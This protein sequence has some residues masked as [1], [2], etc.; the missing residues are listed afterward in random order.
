MVHGWFYTLHVSGLPADS[1]ARGLEGIIRDADSRI[2][3]GAKA[4][5]VGVLSSDNR[6]NWASNLS[7]LVSLSPQ[8]QKTLDFI[9]QSILVL[10]LDAQPNTLTVDGQLH[11][12]RSTSANVGNRWYDKAFTLIVDSAA[13]AGAMGEH[14]PCDA[15]VPSIV[16]EY[17]LVE[18]IDSS[19]FSD[20]QH[21]PGDYRRLEWETDTFIEKQCTLAQTRANAIIANSDDSVLWFSDYGAD[22]IKGV[23]QEYFP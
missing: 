21:T 16:A 4:T 18:G 1:I 8:N 17:G 22:W 3:S 19:Q 2:R 20:T 9:S 5:P 13:R 12:T 7:H 6:D 15:L 11:T 10:S 23:G 14:S